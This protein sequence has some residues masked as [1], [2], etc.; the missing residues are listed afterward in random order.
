M[1]LK[2]HG[3]NKGGSQLM[4]LTDSAAMIEHGT[5]SLS[6]A[7]AHGASKV[8]A[9]GLFVSA[10]LCCCTTQVWGRP[11]DEGLHR[12]WGGGGGWWGLGEGVGGKS[13]IQ[14]SSPTPHATQSAEV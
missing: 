12:H 8:C 7:N 6:L 4:V 9:G 3:C 11:S 5:M 2:R 14:S 1:G 10:F 13:R